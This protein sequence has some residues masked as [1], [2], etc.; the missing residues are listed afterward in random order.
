MRADTRGASLLLEIIIGLG[1]FS[2]GLLVMLAVFPSSHRSLTQARNYATATSIARDFMDRERSVS[3]SAAVTPTDFPFV[4]TSIVDGKTL[5][6]TF[7]VDIQYQELGGAAGEQRLIIV[8]VSWQEGPIDR[9]VRY[10][11]FQV[12]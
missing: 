7:T 8:T 6:T 3:A 5:Q 1:V 2:V 11:T 4:S 10:E 12:I 9:E